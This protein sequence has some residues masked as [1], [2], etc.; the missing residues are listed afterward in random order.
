MGGLIEEVR[1]F[2]IELRDDRTLRLM[3]DKRVQQ[4][5]RS[6]A[7]VM[8]MRELREGN[9]RLPVQGHGMAKRRI[10]DPIHRRHPDDRF[11][12]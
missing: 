1:L 8:H 5:L 7:N 9:V 2:P 6:P 11:G 4:E 10:C 12:E 3:I